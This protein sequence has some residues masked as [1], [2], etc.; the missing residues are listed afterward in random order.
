MDFACRY[1]LLVIVILATTNVVKC[2]DSQTRIIGIMMTEEIYART[3][4]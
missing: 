4:V 1:S 3:G 2:G